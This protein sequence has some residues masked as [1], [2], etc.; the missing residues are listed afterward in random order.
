MRAFLKKIERYIEENMDTKPVKPNKGLLAP[1]AIKKMDK[2]N[3][4][5]DIVAQVATYV[6]D[7]RKQRMEL[8]ND[9]V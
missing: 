5:N 7:I 2:K 8:K 1:S 4:S 6:M 9:K 3:V